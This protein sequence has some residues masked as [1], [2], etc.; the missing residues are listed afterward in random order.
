[1]CEL[2]TD[3]EGIIDRRA[4][5]S[6]STKSI[7]RYGVECA[8]NIKGVA[9]PERKIGQPQESEFA[10]IRRA[11][12]RLLAPSNE[13]GPYL[14]HC[15][16]I[17]QRNA[18]DAPSHEQVDHDRTAQQLT[19]AGVRSKG[20]Q[21]CERRDNF[22]ELR[23]GQRR[24]CVLRDARLEPLASA[25]LA[26]AIAAATPLSCTPRWPTWTPTSLPGRPG[27]CLQRAGLVIPVSLGFV[28]FGACGPGP[29]QAVVGDLAST[30]AAAA[31][32]GRGSTTNFHK[33]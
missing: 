26:A 29:A 12:I 16:G 8:D 32:A 13:S 31:S 4:Q 18:R 7:E 25:M 30:C 17:V 22:V 1:V 11:P 21:L 3:L 19:R 14:A 5:Q 6:I 2:G 33:S 27:R 28:A 10:R 15:A 23:V 24:Y 20:A 9:S